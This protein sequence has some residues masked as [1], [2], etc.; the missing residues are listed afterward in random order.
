VIGILL[1]GFDPFAAELLK[2]ISTHAAGK[3]YE[4]LAYSGAIAD[5]KTIGWERRSL[6]RLGGTLI[7]A[8]IVVTP[9]VTI[10]GA[11]VPVV[12][13]DPNTESDGVSTVD[14]ANKEGARAATEYLISLGHTRIAH[15]SGR[16]DLASSHLREEGYREALAAAGIPVDENLVRYGAYRS[17]LG[18]VEA[19][20]LLDLDQPPTAIFAANDL[21]AFGALK[22]AEE[23]GLSVPD[24]L[25]VM[26]FDGIPE[27]AYST[28]PLT[29]I[30]QPLHEMGAAAV[31][32]I[33]A[34]LAGQD[35][36]VHS[37]LPTH[38]VVRESTGAP[39]H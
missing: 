22:A 16:S 14:C 24:D 37:L 23:K 20:N 39:R 28:P 11:N 27:A 7:D 12:S 26:G 3:G 10:P 19:L 30:A 15:I 32:V 33:L 6:S 21:S 18:R 17:T 36:P 9:T 25:S 8:A 13:V 31:D 2:G 35:A 38:L 5:F 4:L 1:A 34:R 29:T